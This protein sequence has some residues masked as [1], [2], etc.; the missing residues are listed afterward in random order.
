MNPI[1][2]SLVSIIVWVTYFVTLGISIVLDKRNGVFAEIAQLPLASSIKKA[3][4]WFFGVWVAGF[5]SIIV[6]LFLVDM[7]R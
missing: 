7:T 1:N 5:L 2:P 4:Y 6:I 3:V